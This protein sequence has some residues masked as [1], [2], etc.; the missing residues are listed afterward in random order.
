MLQNYKYT[1]FQY[2][3]DR[4][5]NK[6]TKTNIQIKTKIKEKSRKKI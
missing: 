1:I 6:M 5:S 3:N 4:K 2:K